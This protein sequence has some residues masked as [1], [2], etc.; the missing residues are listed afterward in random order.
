MGKRLR[1]DRPCLIYTVTFALASGAFTA[2]LV[3]GFTVVDE[4]R[5]TREYFLLMIFCK[6][7]RKIMFMVVSVHPSILCLCMFV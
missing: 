2:L 1:F 7:D 5:I 4:Y 3:C 6:Q